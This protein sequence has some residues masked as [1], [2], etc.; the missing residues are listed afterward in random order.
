MVISGIFPSRPPQGENMSVKTVRR[1]TLLCINLKPNYFFV[2]QGGGTKEY[3]GAFQVPATQKGGKRI[4]LRRGFVRYRK[5]NGF[6]E[7]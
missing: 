6:I 3:R 2:F 4:G 7:K 5:P 1:S